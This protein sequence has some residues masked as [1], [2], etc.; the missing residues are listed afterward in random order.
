MISRNRVPAVPLIL[1][2]FL[3]SSFSYF[4][5]YVT[6]WNVNTRLA[7]TYAIVEE[8]SFAIDSYHNTRTMPYLWTTDKAIFNGHF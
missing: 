5:H 4:N 6:G 2:F 1:F 7:L 3:W 8:K